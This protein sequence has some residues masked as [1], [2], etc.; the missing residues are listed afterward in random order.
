MVTCGNVTWLAAAFQPTLK[1]RPSPV[2]QGLGMSDVSWFSHFFGAGMVGRNHSE[3]RDIMMNICISAA[4]E[5]PGSVAQPW[6]M[7]MTSHC[8]P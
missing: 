3:V 5:M 8:A 7:D 6:G 2:A 4:E 1:T